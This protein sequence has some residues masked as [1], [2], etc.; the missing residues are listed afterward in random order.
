MENKITYGYKYNDSFTEDEFKNEVFKFLLNSR[1]APDYIFDEFEYSNVGRIN[2]PLII[3]EGKSEIEYSRMLGFDRYETTTKVKTTTYSNGFSN[4]TQSSSTRTITDW[5]K[6]EGVLEGT[7]TAGYYDPKYELYNEYVANHVMDKNNICTLTADE[8]K[9]YEIS[10]E[11]VHNLK[12]DI[13]NNVFHNNIT[14]PTNNVKNEEYYGTTTIN[15]ITCTI[16]SLYKMVI[17]IRDKQLMFFACS[18]GEI[19]MKY[20]GEFPLDDDYIES[21]N[22]VSEIITEKKKETKTPKLIYRLSFLFGIA[23]FVT[24]LVLGIQNN[25]TVLIILSFIPL[26]IGF[27]IGIKYYKVASKINKAYSNKVIAYNNDKDKQRFEKKERSY[28][29]LINK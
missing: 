28:E 13:L 5:K 22:K 23:I 4:R 8:I 24:F 11:V 9:N 2:I 16:V 15:N 19:E 26:I 14:Y 20:F 17:S 1:L 12:N 27:V 29:R 25:Q 18:N 10:D 3:A 6:D 7:A 21:M